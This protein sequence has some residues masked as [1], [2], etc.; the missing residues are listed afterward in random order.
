VQEAEAT[1]AKEVNRKA[2]AEE[3]A[4]AERDLQQAKMGVVDA[5]EAVQDATKEQLFAQTILNQVL[6]GATEETDAYK[7]ALKELTD[8]KDDEEEARRRVADAILAEANATLSLAAAIEELNKVKAQTPANIVRKGTAQLAGIATDNP[9][10]DI[11][12]QTQG[13]GADNTTVN[14]QVNAGMGTDGDA[15]ARQIIDVLKGYERAN[16]YVPI[17]SE[18]SAFV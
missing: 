9:A 14:V 18:Y 8:A 1:L 6:N 15:V 16:G 5:T 12:N 4:A 11:L 17:V 10:L 2:S 7:D 3:I 13:N